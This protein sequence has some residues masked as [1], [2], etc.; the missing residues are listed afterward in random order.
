MPFDSQLPET[1]LWTASIIAS[2][3]VMGG[4][5]IAA[6]FIVRYVNRKVNAITDQIYEEVG[7]IKYLI[8]AVSVLFWPAALVFGIYFLSKGKD[9]KVGRICIFILLGT[10]TICFMISCAIVMYGVTHLP[11]ILEYLSD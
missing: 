6:Y 5:I 3:I 9:A 2:I 8:Y 1:A 10:V 11:E 7:A 4:W